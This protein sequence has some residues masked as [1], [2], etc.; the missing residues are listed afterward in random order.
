L[1]FR[2]PDLRERRRRVLPE[3]GWRARRL[4]R[5]ACGT[6]LWLAGLAHLA[7]SARECGRREMKSKLTNPNLLCTRVKLTLVIPRVKFSCGIPTCVR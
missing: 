3:R 1:D 6:A 7:I 5:S 4:A 2:C